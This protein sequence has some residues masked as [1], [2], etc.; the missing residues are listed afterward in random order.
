MQT[1]TN[2]ETLHLLQI[3][4]LFLTPSISKHRRASQQTHLLLTAYYVAV[5]LAWA[6]LTI[7]SFHLLLRSK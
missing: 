1:K 4:N 7:E 6:A 5:D 3:L 2:Q